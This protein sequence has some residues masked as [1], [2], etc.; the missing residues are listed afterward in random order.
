MNNIQFL[1]IAITVITILLM[2]VI[3]WHTGYLR[4]HKKKIVTAIITGSILS[5]G[6]TLLFTSDVIIE[7]SGGTVYSVWF[8]ST[9]YNTWLTTNTSVP[10]ETI[11]LQADYA[12]FNTTCFVTDPT[13]RLNIT[14]MYINSS[15]I[16]PAEDDLCLEFYSNVSDPE[17]ISYIIGGFEATEEYSIRKNTSVWLDVNSNATGFITFDYEFVNDDYWVLFSVYRGSST[18]FTDIIRNYGV[19]YFVWL[20]S[21]TTAYWVNQSITG[22]DEA[23]ESISIWNR[24]AWSN[25]LWQTYNGTRTG[26]N[27]TVHTFQVIRTRLDDAVGNQTI[28]MTANPDMNYDDSQAIILV[29]T[30]TNKG[31]NYSAYNM[32]AAMTLQGI[33]TT[34]IGLPEGDTV[35]RWNRTTFTWDIWISGFGPHDHTVDRWDVIQTKVSGPETWNT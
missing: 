35:A 25:G 34:G 26:V 6:I 29:N 33:N 31:Y 9:S 2:V 13:T 10:F 3:L 17:T 18:I 7:T 12:Y 19:D 24:T 4:R 1:I 21:N 20:G 15:G 30:T 5:S 14:I 8:K 28:T 23:T 32:A 11:T 27:W 16:T 22:M